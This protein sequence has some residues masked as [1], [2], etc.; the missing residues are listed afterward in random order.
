MRIVIECRRCKRNDGT[1]EEELT[2]ISQNGILGAVITVWCRFCKEHSN[3]FL[4]V[5]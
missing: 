5:E 4:T 1:E 2:I 3:Y